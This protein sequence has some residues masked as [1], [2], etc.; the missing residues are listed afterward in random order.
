MKDSRRL[1]L[2]IGNCGG[3]VPGLVLLYDDEQHARAVSASGLK[4]HR[5][6]PV[7]D[8][9]VSLEQLGYNLA[10]SSGSHAKSLSFTV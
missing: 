4:E 8:D 5:A 3:I 9:L 10:R 6:R 2:N 7:I 1:F